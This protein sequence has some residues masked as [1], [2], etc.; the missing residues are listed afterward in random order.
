[1]SGR[2]G[3]NRGEARRHGPRGFTL[4]ELMVAIA[5]VIVVSVI[6]VPLVMALIGD[7]QN[8]GVS[9]GTNG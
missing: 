2:K 4:T 8:K 9:G 5:V 1:M 6:S 3:Q 7:L